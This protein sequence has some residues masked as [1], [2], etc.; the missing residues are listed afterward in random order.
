M[1]IYIYI[2]IYIL[3]CLYRPCLF[4]LPTPNSPIL[5]FGEKITRAKFRE[6]ILTFHLVSFALKFMKSLTNQNFQM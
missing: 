1:Y 2:Y 6:K 4:Q 5:S 3:G